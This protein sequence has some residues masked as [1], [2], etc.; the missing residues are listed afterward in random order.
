MSGP[1]RVTAYVLTF[2]EARQIRAVLE[3]IRWADELILV[4]SFSTDGTVEIANE[5]GAKIVSQKFCGFGKLRNFALDASS[6][7]WL[8]SIDAD[9]RCTPELAAEVRKE[10]DAPRFDAY[11]VPRKSH[12]LGRWIRHCGWYPDYRQPQLFDRRKMRYRDDLVHETYDLNGR[13]GYLREHALQYPWPT[14]EVAT[15]KLQRYST[16][17]AER[18]AASNRS[19]NLGKLLGNPLAMFFKV[20]VVQQGFRDGYHGLILASLY[21]YYTFLKYAKLWELRRRGLSEGRG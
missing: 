5:F 2:Y 4:D 6:N 11:H 9:E 19:A 12:F 3:S 17:M 8:L 10:L 14:I 20:F 16:L 1:N 15:G 18:Y 21:S 7:D 13:L